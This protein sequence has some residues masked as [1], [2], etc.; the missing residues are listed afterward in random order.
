MC[1][2]YRRL[3]YASPSPAT[4]LIPSC[5]IG[6]SYGVS[7]FPTVSLA[8]SPFA[9]IILSRFLFLYGAT[10]SPAESAPSSPPPMPGSSHFRHSEM[11]RIVWESPEAPRD[12]LGKR[13]CRSLPGPISPKRAPSKRTSSTAGPGPI[14]PRPR[15]GAP[16]GSPYPAILRSDTGV[17]AVSVFLG[18]WRQSRRAVPDGLSESPLLIWPRDPEMCS[19][20]FPSLLAFG[21]ATRES[22][23]ILPSCSFSTEHCITLYLSKMTFLKIILLSYWKRCKL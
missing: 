13:I 6:L 15:A 21:Q 4:S 10:P 12:Y 22:R 18:L 20:S 9:F 2:T 23:L 7:P 11:Y 1:F 5:S 17:P 19:G 3:L 8:L 16:L 14:D